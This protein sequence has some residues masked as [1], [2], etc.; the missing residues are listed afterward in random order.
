VKIWPNVLCLNC[1]KKVDMK[2]YMKVEASLVD[3]NYDLI[4][5]VKYFMKFD[6][7]VL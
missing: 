5:E 7:L 1:K 2:K 4:E 6:G 3:N